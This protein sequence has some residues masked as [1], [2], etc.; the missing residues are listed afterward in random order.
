MIGRFPR[1]WV[2]RR[3]SVRRRDSCRSTPHTP[4][5]V[6]VARRRRTRSIDRSIVVVVVVVF[7]VSFT[8]SS[9]DARRAID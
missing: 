9:S 1:P 3:P 7:A 4:S 6:V 2:D 8:R 5:R